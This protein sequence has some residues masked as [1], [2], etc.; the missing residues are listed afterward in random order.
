[1]QHILFVKVV[2]KVLVH[3]NPWHRILRRRQ[4]QH[5]LSLS[6]RMRAVVHGPAT[7]TLSVNQIWSNLI[8]VTIHVQD[9]KLVPTLAVQKEQ[10]SSLESQLAKVKVP[11]MVS[12]H[13]KLPISTLEISRAWTI[14]VVDSSVEK[15]QSRLILRGIIVMDTNHAWMQATIH[16]QYL[17]VLLNQLKLVVI[18]VTTMV[19][20]KNGSVMTPKI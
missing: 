20:A 3:V 15:P 13:H 7:T 11:V 9:T 18:P 8:L 1:M 19:N 12:V 14:T 10:K 4:S 6:V 17:Q 16:H 5:Q 2:A